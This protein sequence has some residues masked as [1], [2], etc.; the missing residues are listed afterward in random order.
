[1]DKYVVDA[2]FEVEDDFRVT[3]GG[4]ATVTHVK[5]TRVN[6]AGVF[7]ERMLSKWDF[8]AHQDLKGGAR[9]TML[10]ADED[11]K[12]GRTIGL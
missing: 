3:S 9:G 4:I 8:R 1:M 2:V 7:M 12:P 11:Q 6:N 5:N 10:C